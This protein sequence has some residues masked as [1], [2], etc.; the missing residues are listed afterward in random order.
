MSRYR[1]LNIN[2]NL[3]KHENEWKKKDA[4]SLNSKEVEEAQT[5][6]YLLPTIDKT[7]VTEADIKKKL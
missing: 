7:G 4:I 6:L 5:F 3:K 1:G 2:I